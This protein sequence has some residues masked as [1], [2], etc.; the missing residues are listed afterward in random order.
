M[1]LG[2]LPG[3]RGGIVSFTTFWPCE[4]FH[5]ARVNPSHPPSSARGLE[6]DEPRIRPGVSQVPRPVFRAEP[7]LVSD[8][9]DVQA[10][11]DPLQ[12]RLRCRI[13]LHDQR[14]VPWD[15]VLR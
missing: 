14:I 7:V 13:A 11:R 1:A 15:D 9:F 12:A 2:I 4:T 8:R 10:D 5:T 3:S 6:A